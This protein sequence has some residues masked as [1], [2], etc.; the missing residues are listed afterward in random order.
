MSYTTVPTTGPAPSAFRDG[1]TDVFY[2]HTIFDKLTANK[3]VKT[4]GNKQLVS[5][6]VNDILDSYGTTNLDANKAVVT[7]GSK[8]LVSMTYTPNSTAST[9]VSRDSNGKS[10][11]VDIESTGIIHFNGAEGDGIGLFE[12]ITSPFNKGKSIHLYHAGM[13]FRNSSFD[14]VAWFGKDVFNKTV[15]ESSD[16]TLNIKCHFLPY[17][18]DIYSLGSSSFKFSGLYTR[19]ISDSSSG[20]VISNDLTCRNLIPN[21]DNT[22]NIGSSSR[23][24]IQLYTKNITD[25]GTNVSIGSNLIPTTNNSYNLG[26]SSSIWSNLYVD[27]VIGKTKILPTTTETGGLGDATYKWGTLYTTNI[28]DDGTDTK[29]GGDDIHIAKEPIT[30]APSIGEKIVIYNGSESAPIGVFHETTSSIAVF[31]VY[32]GRDNSGGSNNTMNGKT[33]Y[34]AMIVTGAGEVRAGS[35]TT[36]SD[37]RAKKDIKD[38]EDFL[39]KI[40]SIR[41]VNYNWKHDNDCDPENPKVTG[42]LAQELQEVLPELVS[43]V[44]DNYAVNYVGLVPM[45]VKCIQSLTAKIQDL[46]ARLDVLEN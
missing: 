20:V 44:D 18:N 16:N 19:N 35:H 15:I 40:N 32:S 3:L 11:F 8:K 42:V 46:E 6:D 17:T 31:N 13:E 27:N 12:N 5:T 14:I 1:M 4:D 23:K 45:L 34:R 38:A 2:D 24:F 10:K 22:F 30:S 9:I 36:F 21:S 28:V 43:C 29:I 33:F 7:D 37:A 41:I 25:N 26:S 39:D